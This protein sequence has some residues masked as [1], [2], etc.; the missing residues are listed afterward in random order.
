MTPRAPHPHRH[1]AAARRAAAALAGAVRGQRGDHRRFN[2]ASKTVT[3]TG[4]AP[5]TASTI[6]DDGTAAHHS[7]NGGAAVD[8]LRRPR[9]PPIDNGQPRRSTRAGATTRSRS[10]PP[11]LQVGHRRRRRRRR[12][13]HRATCRQD[14]DKIAGGDGDDRIIGGR[15]DDT[16]DGGAGND[17]LVWNNGDGND[18]MD[19]DANADEIEV[20]GAHDARATSSRSS[21]PA[22]RARDASTASNLGAVQPRHRRRRAARPSTASA[23]TTR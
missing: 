11:R 18:T 6:G 19:G 1:G 8:R 17:V 7:V 14:A 10:R 15:G 20:N 3:L 9:R 13:R 21:P 12:H 16:M 4:D 22:E 5:A 23:A 2:R